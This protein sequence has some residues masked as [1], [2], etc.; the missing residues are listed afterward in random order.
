MPEVKTARRNPSYRPAP[1]PDR[2]LPSVVSDR[3]WAEAWSNRLG[4]LLVE[5]GHVFGAWLVLTFSMSSACIA[6]KHCGVG[7]ES[8]TVAPRMGWL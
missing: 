4:N 2:V 8:A 1:N 7:A 3:E 5:V 6:S